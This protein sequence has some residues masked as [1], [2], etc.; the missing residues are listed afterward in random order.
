VDSRALR[1]DNNQK[2]EPGLARLLDV[3]PDWSLKD[4]GCPTEKKRKIIIDCT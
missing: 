1:A 4:A 3:Q 2:Q